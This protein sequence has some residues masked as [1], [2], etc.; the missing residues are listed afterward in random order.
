[1]IAKFKTTSS[2][3]RI[4]ASFLDDKIE[5]SKLDSQTKER[6][7]FIFN[8]RLKKKYSKDQALTFFER[9]YDVGYTTAYRIYNKAMMIFGELDYV[10]VR[11]ER[12]ILSEQY[13]ELYQRALRKDDLE[14][15]GKML[16]RFGKLRDVEKTESEL[17]DG[18]MKANVYNITIPRKIV[19]TINKIIKEKG[20]LDFNDYP[21][22]DIPHEVVS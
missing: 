16:D 12:H 22:E 5:L 14:V 1:M 6:C 17:E 15:A 4:K 21:A 19:K 10:F 13:W 2:I 11:A 9:E 3:E 18:E 8:L 7:I 20:V